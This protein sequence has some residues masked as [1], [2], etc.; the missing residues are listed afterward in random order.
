MNLDEFFEETDFETALS[1]AERKTDN[2][3]VI[4]ED[5][6]GCTACKI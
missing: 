2:Q 4:E 1:E 6:D 5:E 3:E